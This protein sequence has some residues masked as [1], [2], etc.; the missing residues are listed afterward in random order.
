MRFSH[1]T[2]RRL[3]KNYTHGKKSTPLIKCKDCG[4]RV[5]RN[6]L[7]RLRKFRQK[8]DKKWN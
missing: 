7:L 4:K 3:K 8:R 2:H 1:C 6:D 5:T